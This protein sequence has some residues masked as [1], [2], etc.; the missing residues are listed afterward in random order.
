MPRTPSHRAGPA[1]A[2][3]RRRRGNVLQSGAGHAR[4]ARLLAEDGR[5]MPIH[6]APRGARRAGL[7]LSLALFL[8]AACDFAAPAPAT[9]ASGAPLRIAGVSGA[10][11]SICH[12]AA[13][14][15]CAPA[16]AGSL[17]N[18]DDLVRAG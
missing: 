17:A 12:R 13:A 9:P 16:A 6:S 5:L 14:T 15:D 11:G 1:Q 2:A 18:Y 8:L 10:G 7:L 3:P 4:A